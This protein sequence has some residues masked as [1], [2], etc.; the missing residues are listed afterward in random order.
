M[1]SAAQ[2]VHVDMKASTVNGVP[3]AI[4]AAQAAPEAPAKNVSVIPMAQCLSPVTRSQGS[5][6]ADLEPRGPSVMAASTGMHERA[7]SVFSVE[8]SAQAF[9]SGTWSTWSRW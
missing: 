7:R 6:S 9:F 5:A 4:L 1:I 2:L 3:L 8:M